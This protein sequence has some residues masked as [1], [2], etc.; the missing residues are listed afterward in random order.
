MRRMIINRGFLLFFV[1]FLAATTRP[2]FPDTTECSLVTEGNILPIY[3]GKDKPLGSGVL[4]S[5]EG[6]LITAAHVLKS[7]ANDILPLEYEIHIGDKYPHA[8]LIKFDENFDVALLKL[9]PA[10]VSSLHDLNIMLEDPDV[11]GGIAVCYA[12]YPVR[13]DS[14]GKI[15]Q[16]GL[17]EQEPTTI[18]GQ[19]LGYPSLSTK[20]IGGYS[21][22]GVFMRGQL[23]GLVQGNAEYKTLFLPIRQVAKFLFPELT[24]SDKTLSS[25]GG[26]ITVGAISK[27]SELQNKV[28]EHDKSIK[29]ILNPIDFKYRFQNDTIVYWPAQGSRAADGVRTLFGDISGKFE[30][31]G[32]VFETS[33]GCSNSELNCPH[34]QIDVTQEFDADGNTVRINLKTYCSRLRQK[35]G[36]SSKEYNLVELR[37]KGEVKEEGISIG[38]VPIVI[39][40]QSEKPYC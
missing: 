1:F 12:G 14:G 7:A 8:R 10:S 5:R 24:Y 17:Y 9:P 21:G 30:H 23:I 19:Y 3:F 22:G 40:P 18:Q 31:R 25:I 2:A 36:P 13:K 35:L 29:A 16:S 37:L 11:T 32:S 34:P 15:I 39:I 4:L 27:F 33:Q 6:Y 28:A 26:E 20:T 38:K